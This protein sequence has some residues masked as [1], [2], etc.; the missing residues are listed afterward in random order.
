[1]FINA[2]FK[3]SSNTGVKCPVPLICHNIIS[4]STLHCICRFSGLQRLWL[5]KTGKLTIPCGN[6]YTASVARYCEGI[7]SKA[8]HHIFR[9]FNTRDIEITRIL[10]TSI[11]KLLTSNLFLLIQKTVEDVIW[12][13]HECRR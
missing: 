1:M 9:R 8:V 12:N 3:I 4:S 6:T 7:K 2:S 10:N 11:P 13:S 5:A